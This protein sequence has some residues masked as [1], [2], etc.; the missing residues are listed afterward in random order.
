[1]LLYTWVFV[2]RWVIVDKYL[3]YVSVYKRFE[4][5]EWQL[6]QGIADLLFILR[7][8]PDIE[9]GHPFRRLFP[10]LPDP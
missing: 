10:H 4:G 7:S 3:L 9:S 8:S 1:M 5:P 6:L 2:Q